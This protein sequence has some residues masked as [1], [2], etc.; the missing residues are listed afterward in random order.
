MNEQVVTQT[1]SQQQIQEERSGKKWLQH[2]ELI[3]AL[4][5]GALILAAWFFTEAK[6]LS[7]TLYILAFVIGGFAKAKEGI[8]DTLETKA[9]NVELLMIFAAV[10]SAL[11]G[12]WAEGAVLIFIFSLSGALE[13]YTMNKS[14]RDLT[15]LM[16]L[17]PEE[18]TLLK[19]GQE[20]RV[21]AAELKIGDMIV[22][23]PG[24]RVAADGIIES[25]ATS[26]DE[27]ALTGE[28]MPAEKTAGDSVFTGTVNGNGSLTV[29]VTKTNEQS[30][31][32]KIIRLVESAQNS[33]SP[34]QAF[35]ERFESVYVKG[36]LLAV[37]L[38]LFVP[39][40]ALGWSWSETF[41]RAMVFMV[42]ASPC[43]L[44]ASIMPAALSLISN[45]A[46]NGLLVKGSVFLEQL[47]SVRMIAFDKTGT[48]TKGQ[49]AVAAF[50]AAEQV[51]EDEIMQ[52]VY[53]IEKQSS[54]PLAKAIAEFAESRGAVPA[55][56]ISIDETSGFGVQADIEGAKWMIGKA[57]F[58]GK[59]DA[60]AF[61]NT[62]GN[63][64]KDKGCTLVFVKKDDRIAG[65]FALKDQI[66]PEAKAVMAELESLGIKT[67][68]L[69]GDQ[70]ETAAAIAN[71]AGMTTVVADCLPDQKAE[72]VKKL[73]ET[74]G[75][76]AMVG[77]GIN[78]APALKTADVGIAMG[79][80]TDVALETADLVLMKNDLHKLVKMCRLSRK[81][82][83][84]IKQNIVFSLSVICLLIC[85]NFLQVMELP[86]GVIGHEGST[87]LVILNGL[88]LLK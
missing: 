5:S 22:I 64:L 53:T 44:V 7:V 4:V 25:G 20:K 48:V 66:R 32:R 15:S 74:Y 31:F 54:H 71:E 35:I 77:D 46:R 83:R 1:H 36:V 58:A 80:G 11:I 10:G 68:M 40:F 65:C 52:A 79:G 30:L 87:I 49:P 23:K 63:E 33:V 73:K 76:I 88:R 16:K 45:G 62:S 24:E 9:L 26:L 18:A 67:A 57:G 82:N 59:E 37:A 72:E 29:R 41:Y 55:G 78:D 75:T 60:D 86:F 8:E 17:E 50:Q 34:A 19:D 13:T 61:L 47:G 28:S 38:L 43:A 85:A 2:A 42:V 27:S 69:T 70:P 3:A 12:Y 6:G 21:P 14:S 51:N 39:H 56:H 84:I 81:M